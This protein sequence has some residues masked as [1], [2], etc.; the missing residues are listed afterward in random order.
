MHHR[1]RI[2]RDRCKRRGQAARLERRTQESG[3][4]ATPALARLKEVASSAPLVRV[5]GRVVQVVGLVIESVGPNARIGDLCLILSENGEAIRSEVVGF[6]EGRT[7]LMPLGELKG[8]RSG[9]MVLGRGRCL[10]VPFGK[11]LLGRTLN[12]LGEPMDGLG[13]LRS[14]GLRPVH[15]VP[16]NA[17]ERRLIEIPFETGVRAI[18]SLMTV[19][20]GQRIGIFSGSG[21]GKSTLLGMIARHCHADVN[22]IALVGERGREVREFI[23]NDLGP[24]GLARSIVVCATSEQPALVRIKAAMTATAIAEGF[25]DQGLRVLLMM[26]SVTRFAMAQREVGLA[27]GEP[28]ST[29]GYTPSVFALLP[30]LLERAG[31]AAKGSI[32]GIYSVLVEGDDTNEPVADSVRSILDGHIVLTRK[33]ANRGHYPPIDPLQSLSRTMPSVVGE[34]ELEAARQARELLAA[35][36][37]IEDLVNIGAYKPGANPAA[38]RALALH[39]KLGEFLRQRT[40]DGCPLAEATLR[41]KE[42]LSEAV[43]IPA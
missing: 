32:T 27:V 35:Y 24:D 31:N 13:A 16:P 21:I 8:V 23:K 19:G 28:P 18:D 3:V 41:L 14:E 1:D 7:L 5:Y 37:D 11:A 10:E 26:D 20:E 22:V 33:L 40:D 12:G 29:K 34:E 42:I 15:A 9:C 38:D 30:R 2:R 17:L 39:P 4:S 43:P 36:D 6:R 25:R